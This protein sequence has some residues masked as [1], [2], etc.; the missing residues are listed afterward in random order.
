ML[1][2]LAGAGLVYVV[3]KV[4]QFLVQ[5]YAARRQFLASPIPGPPLASHLTG[6]RTPA[7][8]HT[9]W[10]NYAHHPTYQYSLVTTPASGSN[11]PGTFMSQ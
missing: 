4:V 1:W 2:L 6:T 7:G 5:L 3:L 10:Y 11:W 9:T 8:V